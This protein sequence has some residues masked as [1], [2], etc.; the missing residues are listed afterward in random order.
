MTESNFV[1]VLVAPGGTPLFAYKRQDG[2][3]A[4]CDRLNQG[5]PT[6]KYGVVPMWVEE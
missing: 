5:D 2:A 6:R 3:Q 1:Y 4:A